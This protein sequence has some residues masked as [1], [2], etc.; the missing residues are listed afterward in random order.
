MNLKTS[1]FLFFFFYK[2]VKKYTLIIWIDLIVF[3]TTLVNFL[4]HNYF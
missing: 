4:I 1:K 3:A 2:Y